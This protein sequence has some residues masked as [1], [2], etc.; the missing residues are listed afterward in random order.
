[1]QGKKPKKYSSS[2]LGLL[3]IEV[4]VFKSAGRGHRW[5]LGHAAVIDLQ[6]RLLWCSTVRYDECMAQLLCLHTNT[7]LV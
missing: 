2:R 5:V 4:Y 6:L 3:R 1:M 7:V